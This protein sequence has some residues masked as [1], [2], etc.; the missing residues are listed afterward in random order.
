MIVPSAESFEAAWMALKVASNLCHELEEDSEAFVATFEGFRYCLD[1]LDYQLGELTAEEKQ[2]LPAESLQEVEQ[3]IQE[4]FAN[5]D[6]P[7][8]ERLQAE[9]VYPEK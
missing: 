1:A 6:R 3:S 9:E 5:N 8:D 7:T 4:F 2:A